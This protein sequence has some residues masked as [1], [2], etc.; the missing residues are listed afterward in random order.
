MSSQ[1][2]PDFLAVHLTSTITAKNYCVVYNL[3]DGTV[4]K[5]FDLPQAVE[6][7]N[8]WNIIFE[9]LTKECPPKFVKSVFLNMLLRCNESNYDLYFEKVKGYA[10]KFGYT[11][12]NWSSDMILGFVADLLTAK[13]KGKT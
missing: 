13:E 8:D 2:H 7:E 11:N 12:F 3:K 1:N 6:T 9:L 4:W 5:R 10:I